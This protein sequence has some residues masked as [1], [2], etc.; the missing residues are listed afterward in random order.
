[1]IEQ[2]LADHPQQLSAYQGGK[3]KLLGFFIGQVMKASGGQVNPE[4]L[5]QILRTKLEET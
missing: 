3:H 5:N 4:R 1:M 2:V